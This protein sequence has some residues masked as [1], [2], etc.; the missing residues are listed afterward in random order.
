MLGQGGVVEDGGGREDG[1]RVMGQ[2][3]R[4]RGQVTGMVRRGGVG[5]GGGGVRQGG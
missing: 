1:R 5:M 3:G 2:A 4:R